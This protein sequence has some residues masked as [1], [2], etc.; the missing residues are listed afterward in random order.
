MELTYRTRRRL[1][2]GILTGV[3]IIL[4]LVLIWTCWVVWVERY[5]VFTR[6]G[7]IID[8]SLA[9]QDP[10]W[11]QVAAPMSSQE[12]V[13]IYYNDGD[14]ILGLDLSLRQMR[15]Y[16]ITTE[17]LATGDL[18]TIRAAVSALPVGS[19]VM[20]E[21]KNIKGHFYYST[22]ITDAPLATDV[23]VEM[24]DALIDDIVSR[25]LYFVASTPAFRDRNYG[26]EHTNIGIPFVGGNGALW[27]DSSNC[28][29]LDPAKNR[30]VDYLSKIASELRMKGFD[31]VLFTDFCIPDSQQIDYSGNKLTAVQ[32][33]AQNLVDNCAKDRFAVSFMASGSTLHPVEGRSR[34]YLTG[35]EAEQIEPTIASYAMENPAAGLVFLTDSF[36]TRYDACSVLR[37]LNLGNTQ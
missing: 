5:V 32:N 21:V 25:N 18:E 33:A 19:M 6:E 30:T 13:S 27:L 35:V 24:V 37:P 34:L 2:H 11:G 36:D 16:Y 28:Y 10:G 20:M 7:A 23:D 17:M 8:F 4:A 31:E 26:L 1:K 3:G 29:W 15:G 12:P 22:S 9:D 14:D